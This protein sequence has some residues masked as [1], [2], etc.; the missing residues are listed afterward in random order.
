MTIRESIA[1]FAKDAPFKDTGFAVS[2]DHI[3]FSLAKGETDAGKHPELSH[4]E[5]VTIDGIPVIQNSFVSDRMLWGFV[6]MRLLR[7]KMP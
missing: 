6:P 1:A 7:R 5:H 4:I 2:V 3:S